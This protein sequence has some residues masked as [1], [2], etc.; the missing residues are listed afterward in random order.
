MLARIGAS[1]FPASFR[2]S[3][4]NQSYHMCKS[5]NDGAGLIGTIADTGDGV[6]S[7]VVRKSLFPQLG[8]KTSRMNSSVSLGRSLALS[9]SCW[10]ALGFFLVRRIPKQC[11]QPLS[12]F[13]G[14]GLECK[15][16]AVLLNGF[17][18]TV[19]LF[20]G[21]G[22]AQVGIPTTRGKRGRSTKAG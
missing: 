11:I 17:R 1:A 14:V 12:C 4:W 10:A 7:R 18:A 15:C 6:H 21:P 3:L 5:L 9:G 20:A 16:P 19:R 22:Q 2:S 13:R 8:L